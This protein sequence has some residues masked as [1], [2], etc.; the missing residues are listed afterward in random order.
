LIAN[1]R[2]CQIPTVIWEEIPR[3]VWN[4]HN[5][6][7]HDFHAMCSFVAKDIKAHIECQKNQATIQKELDTC[8]FCLQ[9]SC[10]QI[11][12]ACDQLIENQIDD[13]DDLIV[14]DPYEPEDMEIDDTPILDNIEFANTQASLGSYWQGFSTSEL[15][16]IKVSLT[17]F[18]QLIT[19][20]GRKS[21]IYKKVYNDRKSYI[22]CIFLLFGG[23]IISA[24]S[25]MR[26][27]QMISISSLGYMYFMYKKTLKDVDAEINR[28]KDQL[29]SLCVDMSTHLENNAKKY[30]AISAGIFL[31]YGFYKALKPLLKTQDKSTYLDKVTDYFSTALDSPKK[32]EYVYQTQDERNYKEGYSRLPPR[33]SPTSRT[34]T[35]KD[36]QDMIAR[37]LRV[38][39]TKSKGETYN[40][41]NGIMVASNVI[42][43]PS[44]AVPFT[45]PFSIETSTTPG[46]PSAK[47]KDQNLTEEYVYIDRE[48]DQAFIHLASCPA[49]RDFSKYFADEYPTFYNRSTVLMWKSPDNE[50]KISKHPSRPN[51]QDV[52]Y[53][54]MIEHPGK[55]WGVKQQFTMFNITKGEGLAYETQF[56]GFCGL[57][58][59]LLVDAEKAIIYGYHVAGFTNS[60]TGWSTV[61]LRSHIQKALAKL[62]ETSPTLVVHSADNV[63]VDTYGLPYTVVDAK[64]LYLREDGNQDKTIVTFLGKVKK[65]GMDMTSNQRTPYMPTPFKGIVENFGEKRHKPPRDPNDVSKSMSTLNKLTNPVQ[66]YEGDI[67]LKAIKDYEEHTLSVLKDDPELPD[68]MRI[69]TQEEAMDGI[70][71]FGLGGIPNSTSAGFPIM[72]SKKQCLKKDPLDESLVKVPREFDEQ[73]DIQSEVD[74]TLK[75]WSE[76]LRS[77]TIYKA[78]SKVNELLPIKKA[79]TKVRKFY[80]SSFANFVASRRV[81]AGIP[82]IMRKHWRTTE[83]LVGINAQSR[84]WSEFHEYLTEYGTKNMI[85]GD[86]AGFDTRMAAQ[87]TAAAAKIMISWYKSAGCSDEDIRLIEGAL[88]DIIHPNILID[89]DLYRFANGNP[90]GNLITVQLNSICN[91]IMM[92]YVYYAQ[93]PKIKES[94]ASNVRLATYGDDN[95]MSVKKHCS[96]YTHTSC[97]SEFAKLDIEYTMA[98][99][100]AKSRPYIP[101][102][103]ISFLKRSFRYHEELKIVVAPIESDSSFKKLHW[104]KKP[105]ESPL[106][107]TEQF[108]AHTDTILRDRYLY[109]REIYNDCL[110]KLK[111]VVS[112]NDNLLGVVNFIP[113][114]IMTQILKPDYAPTYV[115]KHIKLFLDTQGESHEDE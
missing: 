43:I 6:E 66:H 88:S 74:R 78:N 32:G 3:R 7:S 13:S 105:S 89:G 99:K 51:E 26:L 49:S 23:A 109:G 38:V 67:L 27:A 12:C 102:D 114:D 71:K 98:E 110:E 4:H 41:V 107:F 79:N 16:D 104:V 111:N 83:C 65:D 34:T 1:D 81:L 58:G 77:E 46:V 33:E 57:C 106:S 115:N 14:E 19:E 96:W 31:A 18:G 11:I 54:G 95:A 87:I 63:N 9:C 25:N 103:E 59:G 64:P 5:D 28:R 30:F 72:K 36:L 40:T 60:Y 39:V 10:P 61:V 52:H 69:Y 45:Y 2:G 29:S 94:F 80:G 24:I 91:S 108:G 42:M 92:R 44:H 56:K 37:S 100:D 68:I 35:S 86:F 20:F 84:E 82:Q 48:H 90:S 17:N 53:A 93:M 113:Y 8:D 50:V 97:Q 70:G 73:Y 112:K 62:K 101:I 21:M 76:G 55:F 75:C 22:N 15:W 47:T 85:A